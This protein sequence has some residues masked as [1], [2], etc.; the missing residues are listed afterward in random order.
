MNRVVIRR[1]YCNNTDIYTFGY[2]YDK[3]EHS[4][5]G[6]T[7]GVLR[8]LRARESL[9]QMLKRLYCDCDCATWS[10]VLFQAIT[11]GMNEYLNKIL[12]IS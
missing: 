4:C 11:T 1:R 3:I 6:Y 10:R 9:G 5:Y 7:F 12:E 8:F 2:S